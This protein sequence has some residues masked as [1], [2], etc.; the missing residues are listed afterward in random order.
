VLC[1]G[2]ALSAELAH[3]LRSKSE[4]LLNGYGPTET[5]IYSLAHEVRAS[6]KSIP[7]GRPLANT[8]VYVLNANMQP[9]PVGVPGELLIGGTGL[10]RGYTNQPELTAEKFVADPFSDARG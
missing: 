5:T 6:E 8:R 7:I 1:G 10:A 9:A 2:E 4:S 3:E